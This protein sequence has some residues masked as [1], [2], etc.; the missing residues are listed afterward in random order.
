MSDIIELKN[1]IELMKQALRFY[2]DKENWLFYKNKDAPAAL[3]E[4]AQARFALEQL[5]KID[6]INEELSEDYIKL[7]ENEISKTNTPEGIK[8]LINEIKKIDEN[9]D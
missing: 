6:G 3:D 5:D 4:G 9:G 2:A 7:V 1:Q 8:K